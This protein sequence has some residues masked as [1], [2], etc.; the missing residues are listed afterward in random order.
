MRAVL[1]LPVSVQDSRR[2]IIKFCRRG[3]VIATGDKNSAIS[4]QGCRVKIPPMIEA[5]CD[6]PSSG[7]RVVEIG[8]R[9]SSVTTRDQHPAIQEQYCLVPGATAIEIAGIFPNTRSGQ[10]WLCHEPDR[11][12]D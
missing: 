12:E 8:A 7:H 11:A 5:A 1:R 9:D 6:A 2:R 4:Q 3:V 10:A